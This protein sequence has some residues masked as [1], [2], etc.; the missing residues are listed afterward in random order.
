MTSFKTKYKEWHNKEK[1]FQIV[2]IYVTN[3]L[4]SIEQLNSLHF[5]ILSFI[6]TESSKNLI[7]ALTEGLVT[8]EAL[9]ELCHWSREHGTCNDN[10]LRVLLSDNCIKLMQLGLF[11]PKDVYAFESPHELSGYIQKQMKDLSTEHQPTS[12]KPASEESLLLNKAASKIQA[13]VRGHLSRKKSSLFS[14]PTTTELPSEADM[15]R[16]FR[17]AAATG[18]LDT[19]RALLGKKS[20]SIDAQGPD[21]GKTALHWAA[22]KGHVDIVYFLL[23]EKASLIQDN[24]GLTAYDL[25]KTPEIRRKLQYYFIDYFQNH[26]VT[27]NRLLTEE[28]AIQYGFILPDEVGQNVWSCLQEKSLIAFHDMLKK[29]HLSVNSYINGLPLMMALISV[30]LIAPHK[31]IAFLDYFIDHKVDLNLK[32]HSRQGDAYEGTVLHAMLANEN[33]KHALYILNKAVKE[34]LYIDST[35][36]DV[37]GKTIILMGVLLRD[38]AFLSACLA[39]LGSAAINIADDMGRTPLHYAYLFG[40]HELIELLTQ[41]GASMECLDKQGKRPVDMLY[42]NKRVLS[43]KSGHVYN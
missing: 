36:R 39:Q 4:F 27:D 17:K 2:T 3:G 9:N 23:D 34:G 26:A 25:T 8:V 35:I 41:H 14:D 7:P 29:H 12:Q 43:Q 1:L 6:T 32:A 19:C 40:D 20:F 33:V 24:K 28:D 11:S 5:Y 21:S 18:D 13:V 22:E 10:Y 38:T 42:E 37:E 16:Q 15:A 30:E 31:N